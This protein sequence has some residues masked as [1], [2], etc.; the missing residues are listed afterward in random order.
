[1]IAKFKKLCELMAEQEKDVTKTERNDEIKCKNG[2]SLSKVGD[3]WECGDEDCKLTKHYYPINKV[4]HL[5]GKDL[6]REK[7][8]LNN[9]TTSF[10]W[11][12]DDKDKEPLTRKEALEKI[13]KTMN[14]RKISKNR[15]LLEWT[16]PT[17]HKFFATECQNV[18]VMNKLF[19]N[20]IIR[21]DKDY[22]ELR[23]MFGWS[24]NPKLYE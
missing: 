1:M 7:A 18:M 19:K 3:V 23:N 2:H 10:V 16:C 13:C 9:D 6:C 12:D 24:K 20:V 4:N 17:M 5:E 21:W 8:I 14:N 22:L 11:F 15:L